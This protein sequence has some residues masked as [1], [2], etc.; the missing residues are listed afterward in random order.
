MSDNRPS[1]SSPFVTANRIRRL[2]D[3]EQAD[4]AGKQIKKPF[5]EGIVENKA[6]GFH[7]KIQF[8]DGGVKLFTK[9][10]KEFGPSSTQKLGAIGDIIRSKFPHL[11]HTRL[12][13]PKA[14]KADEM[15]AELVW[16]KDDGYGH[17]LQALMHAPKHLVQITHV[18]IFD[19]DFAKKDVYVSPAEK[20]ELVR[21]SFGE[22]HVVR[23]LIDF[24][25]PITREEMDKFEEC[26]QLEEGVVIVTPENKKIKHKT[27]LPVPLRL[28]AI[29]V[30]QIGAIKVPTHFVWV[31]KTGKGCF[32][33]VLIDDKT[34]LF[35]HTRTEQ[36]KVC[37]NAGTVKHSAKGI[38]CTDDTFL[39]KNYN[40]LLAMAKDL[41]EPKSLTAYEAK[42]P[43]PQGDGTVY[44]FIIN[45]KRSTNFNAAKFIFLKTPAH[46]VV[47]ANSIWPLND[48]VHIQA[49]QFLASAAY[50]HPIHQILIPGVTNPNIP[51]AP[52]PL[53]AKKLAL[54][55]SIPRDSRE[56]ARIV[57]GCDVA[58]G[59]D[60]DLV[61][62]RYI[63]G[64][65]PAYEED[66]DYTT[67]QQSSDED[68][69]TFRKRKFDYEL[70][71]TRKRACL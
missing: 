15:C 27:I 67:P 13:H 66:E 62:G 26:M 65:E 46:G 2:F 9:N 40:A 57:Y 21:K 45:P 11:L 8:T 64:S 16:N 43:S 58:S 19:I 36:G 71:Y 18:F 17:N 60:V 7:L 12:T 69:P 39:G 42:I 28:A 68:E 61:Y 6:D 32:Q 50:G 10:G 37:I 59:E 35:D 63:P 5:G 51:L 49:P 70:A 34:H 29:G 48:E 52:P 56:H 31:I 41:I 33:V 3:E 22:Q 4:K 44:R 24:S 1:G 30:T 25:K 38:R 20:L 14:G 54:L 47:G 53:T 23:T 55:A